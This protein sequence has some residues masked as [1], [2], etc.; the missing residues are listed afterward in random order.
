MKKVLLPIGLLLVSVAVFGQNQQLLKNATAQRAANNHNFGAKDASGEVTEIALPAPI[1]AAAASENPLE[2]IVGSATYDLQTN[3][4]VM[5]RILNPGDG[6]ITAVWTFSDATVSTFV[7]RGTGYAHFDG[8]NWEDSPADR[9]ESKR[10]G[11]PNLVTTASGKELIVNHNTDVEDLQ[12]TSRSTIGSGSWSEDYTNLASPSPDGNYWPR[13]TVGGPDGNTVHVISLTYPVN[14]S[15]NEGSIYQGLDGA[16]TYSRS[17]DG[18]STW[19]STHVIL[20][21][22]DSSNYVGFSADDYAFANTKGDTVAFVVGG[23][24]QDL[25]LMKSVDNGETWT[26]TIIDSFPVPMFDIETTLVNDTTFS[27]DGSV[28]VIL[29][30]DGMAHVFYGA[31]PVLNDDISDDPPVYSY[32]FNQSVLYYWNESYGANTRGDSIAAM[33]DKD[34]D[35]FGS[36]ADG[37]TL[38]AGYNTA[39]VGQPSAGID[40]DGNL[41]VVY[42]GVVEDLNDGTFNYRHVYLMKSTDGGVTWTEPVDLNYTELDEFRECVFASLATNVDDYLHILYQRDDFPGL[43]V[44]PSPGDQADIATNEI[45]YVKVP[46]ALN[47]GMAEEVVLHRDFN[48]YPNPATETVTINFAMSRNE[49]VVLSVYD[50]MGKLV[51]T[52]TNKSMAGANQVTLD[53]SSLNSGI[54]FV[55]ATVGEQQISRKLV[56][57]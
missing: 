35:G 10:T 39:T 48:I 43:F 50:M 42:S 33:V 45:V 32:F 44:R 28:A 24:F 16:I 49:T 22:M 47:V 30:D 6:T 2:R 54:Y 19:D 9:I 21:G 52:F 12:F 14:S 38:A 17:L 4:S 8:T 56:V 36:I 27:N 53:V 11:W 57:E 23:T 15:T 1:T 55:N 26:K 3:G 5:S 31:V 40:A 7:D 46:K 41:Y 25:F 29:D 13:A 37:A 34:G 51:D 20:P 18:G